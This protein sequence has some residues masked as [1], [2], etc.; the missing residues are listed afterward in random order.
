MINLPHNEE[1]EKNIIGAMLIDNQIITEC[2]EIVKAESFYNS[3]NRKIF[4]AICE[5]AFNGDPVDVFI[6]LEKYKFQ[7]D[8]LSEIIDKTVTSANALTYCRIV[9]E[10]YLRRR[11][12]N[13]AQN[14]LEKYTD[15]QNDIFELMEKTQQEINNIWSGFVTEKNRCLANSQNDIY[16]EITSYQEGVIEAIKTPNY[17]INYLLRGGAKESQLIGIAARTGIGKTAYLVHWA[18][19]LQE[20]IPVQFYSMEM[21]FKQIALRIVANMS[22]LN[23][24]KLMAVKER[25]NSTEWEKLHSNFQRLKSS[26]LYINDASGWSIEKLKIDIKNV[27][28][29]Y[30]IKIIFIDFLQLIHAK[31]MSAGTRDA[32]LTYICNMLKESSKDTGIPHIVAVQ[33]NRAGDDKPQ[34]KHLRE[35]GGIEQ[36]LDIC[37]FLHDKNKENDQ[38]HSQYEIDLIVAKNRD[39]MNGIENVL[40]NK[41]CFRFDSIDRRKTNEFEGMW[42]N[43]KDNDP[44]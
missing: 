24:Y 26:K 7:V 30:G 23:T 31:N 34:L 27:V 3:T 33:V 17:Y 2:Q 28:R 18:S 39:G 44:F 29:K 8:Y 16:N 20:K 42:Y 9:Q 35:S 13:I 36:A 21:S 6:L 38:Y 15:S 10:H 4:K 5:I 25:M 14:I 40:Y 43:E 11:Y 32:E 22:S 37:I 41:E 1:M 12:I 19:C